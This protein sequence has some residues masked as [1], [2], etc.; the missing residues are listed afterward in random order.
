MI[1]NETAKLEKPDMRAAQLLGV[2]QFMEALLV[3][4]HRRALIDG[5]GNSLFGDAAYPPRGRAAG[6]TPGRLTWPLC[7][8]GL[9]SDH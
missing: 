8:N 7:P 5:H 3:L 1:V 9:V 4:C 2:A 6:G